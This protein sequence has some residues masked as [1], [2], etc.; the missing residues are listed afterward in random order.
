M[1]MKSL[2]LLIFIKSCGWRESPV[3]Q[4]GNQDLSVMNAKNKRL[5]TKKVIFLA[6]WQKSSHSCIDNKYDAY[7]LFS[8]IA[9]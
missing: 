9:F 7:W 2:L 4:G 5:L 1:G 6:I 3:P 8:Q